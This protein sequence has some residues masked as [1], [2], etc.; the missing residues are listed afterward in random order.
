MTSRKPARARIA[1]STLLAIAAPERECCRLWAARRPALGPGREARR[2]TGP[3]APAA[4]RCCC[5]CF[6]C[7]SSSWRRRC[8]SINRPITCAQLRQSCSPSPG[9]PRPSASSAPSS[10]TATAT[11]SYDSREP[12]P[13]PCSPAQLCSKQ[14]ESTSW[15]RSCYQRCFE[16]LLRPRPRPR[17]T[18][19]HIDQYPRLDDDEED[20]TPSPQPHCMIIRSSLPSSLPTPDGRHRQRQLGSGPSSVRITHPHPQ[21]L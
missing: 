17:P 10:A 3:P 13:E 21:S 7:S 14:I 9:G 20:S 1:N 12:S 2:A 18:R 16:A 8:R 11:L 6:C 4:L 19:S 15:V 5:C